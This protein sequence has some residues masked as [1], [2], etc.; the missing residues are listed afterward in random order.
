MNTS[1]LIRPA[2]ADDVPAIIGFI[3]ELAAYEKLLH[4]VKINAAQLQQHLFGPN[5][6][7]YALMAE[8]D[9]SRVGYALYFYNFS[10]FLGRPGMFLEDLYIQPASRGRGLGKALLARL[11]QIAVAEDCGRLEWSVLDWNEPS[12]KFYKSMGAQPMDDWTTMRMTGESLTSLAARA[13]A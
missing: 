1:I 10:T 13:T 2:T 5:P 7:V 3:H 9:G 12:I 4:E 8:I 11:A 6:K